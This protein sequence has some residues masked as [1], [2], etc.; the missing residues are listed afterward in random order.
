MFAMFL[1]VSCG[2]ED[3]EEAPTTGT[4]SGTVT[5]MGTPPEDEINVRVS[6]FS[7][8]DEMGRPTGPPDHYSELFT[9]L[10]GQVTYKISGVSFGEYNLAAVGLEFVGSPTGTPQTILGAYGMTPPDDMQA[11]PFTVSE[12]Q[13]DVTGI[14]IIASYTAAESSEN[15]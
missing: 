4:V 8:V 1:M 10:T 13:P 7:V 14:D 11:D 3:E 9:E 12:D 2:E 5:F 15:Q 6:I